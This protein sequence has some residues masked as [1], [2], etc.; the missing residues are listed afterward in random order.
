MTERLRPAV[1]LDRDGV[2]NR[3]I[4]RGGKPYPPRSLAELEVL[5]GVPEALGRLRRAGFLLVGVTN[6]PDVARGTQRREVVEAINAALSAALPLDD[7]VTCYDD[8]DSPRRKPNPGM[9]LEAAAKHNI[10]LG[11]SFLIGDRWKDIEAGRRAGCRTVLLDYQYQE[12][13][14]PSITSDF[15]TGDI[16]TAAHW[17]LATSAEGSVFR[18]GSE[19]RAE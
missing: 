3:S 13:K 8:G 11:H 19:N 18:R 9:I 15:I 5:P 10:A 1:F 17:I 4:V 2:L 6:Q 12:A 14:P 16:T 7:I